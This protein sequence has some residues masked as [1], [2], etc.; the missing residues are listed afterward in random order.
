MGRWAQIRD[1]QWILDWENKLLICRNIIDI[2]GMSSTVS[3][4]L[5]YIKSQALRERKKITEKKEYSIVNQ[6]N[7]MSEIIKNKYGISDEKHL[8]RTLK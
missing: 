7:I 8:E 1:L 5:E 6:E 3:S 2:I 4:K